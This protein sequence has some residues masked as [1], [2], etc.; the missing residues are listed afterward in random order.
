MSYTL[1]G[2]EYY[3]IAV[4]NNIKKKPI[5]LSFGVAEDI[6]ADIQLVDKYNAQVYL[7]DITEKSINHYNNVIN[8]LNNRPIDYVFAE[9]YKNQLDKYVN[10]IDTNK[11]IYNHFGIFSK[12]KKLTL[13]KPLNK[14]Y[15]SVTYDITSRIDM[16]KND[17]FTADVFTLESI[18]KKINLNNN[19]DYL[20]INIENCELLVLQHLLLYNIYP[21]QIFIYFSCLNSYNN[22]ISNQTLIS[23]QTILKRLSRFYN[24]TKINEMGTQFYHLVRIINAYIPSKREG[25]FSHT[26]DSFREL[27]IEWGKRGYIKLNETNSNHCWIEDNIILYDR[28]IMDWFTHSIELFKFGLFGNTV[29]NYDSLNCSPWIFWARHPLNMENLEILEYNNREFNTIF[30]GKIENEVQLKYRD[31]NLW[32][33][34][35]D[36]F[37]LVIGNS[38]EKY[39]YTNIEYVNLIRKSRF[40]LSLRG[41]GPKCHREVELMACGTIPIVTRDVDLTYYN[42]IIEGLHYLVIDKPEDITVIINNTS[43]ELWQ[44]MS[45]ACVKWYKENCT[46]EGSFNTTM[47]IIENHYN[48]QNNI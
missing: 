10:K 23:A 19:I 5:C 11:L 20:K 14:S 7:F 12:N 24:I 28:P 35:I 34:H 44:T 29:P 48:K 46:I 9:N 21:K 41:Y 47:N 16:D 26:N 32:K 38:N 25:Y 18:L 2:T 36:F 13:Y 6:L 40:G 3:K 17:S 45:N 43:K 22:K 31:T 4:D 8:Y 27:L 42:N 30:I 39:K 33:K 37:D 15:A 1:L